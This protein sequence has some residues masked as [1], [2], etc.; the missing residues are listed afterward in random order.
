MS[1]DNKHTVAA[2]VGTGLALG[3]GLGIVFGEIVFGDIGIG[4]TLGA[5]V[6]L[7]LGAALKARKK[8]NDSEQNSQ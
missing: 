6:G 3:A 1:A 8:K 5:G 4:L 2:Y 7:T